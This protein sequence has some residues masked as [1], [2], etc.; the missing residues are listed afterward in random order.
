[1]IQRNKTFTIHTHMDKRTTEIYQKAK[2]HKNKE[3]TAVKNRIDLSIDD[4]DEKNDDDQEEQRDTAH[5]SLE[6]GRAE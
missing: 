5:F 3:R 2:L 1:M 4:Q 6:I